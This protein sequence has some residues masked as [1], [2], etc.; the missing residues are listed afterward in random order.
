[1]PKQILLVDDSVTIH[2]IVE[3]TFAHEDFAVTSVKSVDEGLARARELRPDAVLA[4][5]GMPGKTGYDLCSA[6]RQDAALGKTPCLILTGN[7][8]PYDEAKGTAGG[9]DGFVVKP[10]ETQALIDKVKDAIARR[11]GGEVARPAAAAPSAAPSPVPRAGIES[12]GKPLSSVAAETSQRVPVQP[13]AAAASPP[14]PAP[15]PVPVPIAPPVAVTP[16]PGPRPQPKATLMGIPAVNP[17]NIPPARPIAPPPAAH[18]EPPRP[19][20]VPVHVEPPRP[21]H[22]EPPRPVHVE[23]VRPIAVQPSTPIHVEAKPLPPV[24]APRPAPEPIRM[25]P[26]PA[27][28]RPS[29]LSANAPTMPRPSLVPGVAAPRATDT[30]ASGSSIDAVVQKVADR[31]PAAIAAKAAAGGPEYEAIAKLSREVIEQ[32]VWEVVPELAES[33]IRAEL[34]RLVRERQNA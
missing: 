22:V 27:A 17:N 21:V 10:F 19:A 34:D 7:F 31:V 16:P 33:I 23:P 1:M 2:R 30:R 6:L 25:A 32:V 5:A 11:T 20:P 26:P 4:D 14:R 3:I 28:A 9:A 15:L 18:V 24:E 13:P 8:T 12:L 29:T